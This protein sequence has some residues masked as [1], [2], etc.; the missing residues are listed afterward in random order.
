MLNAQGEEAPFAPSP[1][2]SPVYS[3][4]THIKPG[5][6]LHVRAGGRP[7]HVGRLPEEDTGRVLTNSNHALRRRR[8]I[9][10]PPITIS[11]SVAGSGVTVNA[12]EMPSP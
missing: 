5:R 12:V 1:S 8:S 4:G 2:L 3:P 6:P 9:I 10:I 11:P 7:G